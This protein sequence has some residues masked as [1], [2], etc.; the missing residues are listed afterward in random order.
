[1]AE[2]EATLRRAEEDFKRNE[3]LL[4]KHAVSA[5]IVNAMRGALKEAEARLKFAKH[6]EEMIKTGPRVEDIAAAEAQLAARE[7]NIVQVERKLADC[8][9]IAPSDGIVLTRAREKGAIVSPGETMFALTLDS[10]VWARTYVN[11][12]DLGRIEPGMEAE[13]RTDS[14]PGKVYQGR[15]GFISP[16]RRIHP[17]D[18]RNTRAADRPGLSP[19]RDRQQSRRR[20]AP[21]HAGDRDARRRPEELTHG[22]AP[23][24]RGPSSSPNN[25]AGSATPGDRSLDDVDL[26]R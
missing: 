25:S 19:A 26:G 18:R 4:K 13:I 14:A 16:D 17:Q 22:R 10:P 12:R 9:L 11:E 3:A 5:E 1:M 15:I 7:A 6:S 20:P 24:G 2:R 8:V 23:V 21:R